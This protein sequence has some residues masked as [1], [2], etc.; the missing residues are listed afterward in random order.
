MKILL[1]G[2]WAMLWGIGWGMAQPESMT[3]NGKL[4]IMSYNIHNGMGLDEKRDLQRIARV[5][6]QL[7]PDVVAVEEV[8]SATERSGRV[9]MLKILAAEALMYPVFGPAID[10]QGG[11]Y[12]VGILAKEKPVKHYT[13]ALPGRE[14]QRVFL[15]AEFENYVFCA[16]HFSLTEEDQLL[17]VSLIREAVKDYAKP[18]FLAGDLN[19]SPDSPVMKALKK[20]FQPLTSGKSMTFPA[21]HP[22]ECIDYIL[23]LKKEGTSSY[24]LLQ[25][26]VV[27]ETVASDHL[28]VYADVR[29]AAAK[30][31]IFRTRPYLQNP[32]ECGI[33]V[34]WLT[35]VPVYSWVEYGTDPDH[36][37]KAHTVVD[38]QVIANNFIHKIRLNDLQAGKTYYYRVCSREI[39][40]YKA[41]SKV[42]GETAVSGLQSFVVPEDH[43]TD[44][45]ALIFNDVHKQSRTMDSL[46]ARVEDVDYDFVFFNGDC[47]D[48][49]AHE[50]QA[51]Q[52]L[53]YFNEKVGADRVPVFYLRGNHEIRNAY[54]IQLR[55]LFDY[56]GDK[57]YGAFNWGDTRF[58]ML[59]CGE[60]KPDTTWV[61]YGLNDF[62]RL[63]YDQIGFIDQEVHSAAFKRSGK[64]VLIHHVPV[65]GNTDRYQPCRELWGDLLARAPF[66]VSL[67][68]HT[69]RFAY[70]P[71]DKTHSFPVVIG[72]GY[73]LENATVM[74]LSRKGREMTLKVMD[75]GGKI[76]KE[77]KL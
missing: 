65:F 24:A 45:T 42:F 10:Y 64:R 68:A 31:M 54:S 4:R 34:S 47:I 20:V 14:E 56:V 60:D 51:V 39:L 75:A 8:D 46:Y 29:L 13:L 26:G 38:G 58:V 44:F 71:A 57:T 41:Y 61:Y 2:I 73:S 22:T 76:I 28:P 30:E 48:D 18:V 17:S 25:S 55:E 15:V 5:I 62:T 16:T 37:Q 36:L 77:L 12:G 6:R 35:T 23:G 70:H 19:T 32:T 66:H 21:D 50:Q 69:H 53:S 9:D 1:L 7:A 67:N 52:F 3:A 72:G 74:I 43:T 49:P 63:R 40:S 11:R 59:D 33:T 27:E